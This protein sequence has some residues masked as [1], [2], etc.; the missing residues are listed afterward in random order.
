MQAQQQL[1]LPF[2]LE[3]LDRTGHTEVKWN[4][5]DTAS[6]D[7]ARQTFKD[8]LSKKYRA[9]KLTPSGEQGEL[10]TEFNPDHERYLL[11]PP[12]AGG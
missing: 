4:P 2:R 3:V 9:Y 10:V 8:L 12:M 6:V 1:V 7:T 11:M 5:K